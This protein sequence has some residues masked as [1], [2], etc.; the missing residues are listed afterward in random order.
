VLEEEPPDKNNPLLTH[1]KV[2]ITPHIT[3]HTKESAERLSD[4]CIKNLNQY[5]SK[6]DVTS[7]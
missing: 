3:W 5:L 1:P 2:F 7:L 6:M 4:H